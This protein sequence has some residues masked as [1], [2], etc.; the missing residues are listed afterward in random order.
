MGPLPAS[1]GQRRV[2]DEG[3]Y[4]GPEIGMPLPGFTLLSAS[5]T[6]VGVVDADARRAIAKGGLQV[7]FPEVRGLEYVTVAVHGAGEGKSGERPHGSRILA[8][9][10]RGR[11]PPPG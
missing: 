7:A 9:R 11:T 1:D 3:F 4:T 2:P 10:T 6:K 8:E 5:G